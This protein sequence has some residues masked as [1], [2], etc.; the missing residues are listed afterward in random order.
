MRF[1]RT[2]DYY[3]LIQPNDLDALLLSAT[4][5]GYDGEQLL[6]DSE[7]TA[8]ELISSYIKQRYDVTRIFTDTP[9]F[10]NATTYYAQNR[11][12]YHEPAYNATLT[13]SIGDRRSYNN[14]IYEANT[15]IGTP[16]AFNAAKWDFVCLDYALYYVTL[17][18]PEFLPF[19]N[20]V[21]SNQVWSSDNYTY[22]ALKNTTGQSL[23]N[24]V[25]SEYGADKNT[26][27]YEPNT[28]YAQD[29]TNSFSWQRSVSKYSITSI[30]PT[31][32]TK[33]TEGDN[34]SQLIIQTVI[35]IALFNL[36]SAISP[37]NIPELRLIRYDGN[38]KNA[39]GGAIGW[40]KKIASGTISAELPERNPVQGLPIVWGSSFPKSNNLY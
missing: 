39:N 36:F 2:S 8:I 31:D 35:D 25:Y 37:R 1:L 28:I 11:V 10:D 18:Y 22:T 29:L 24:V 3:R 13:Y 4:N 33:W 30:L 16:E 9:D 17:P 38:D 34:R 12:Q 26:S 27:N 40:L 15:T 19:A 32:G 6:I 5:A 20:Y 14:K 7:N 23:N 21:A